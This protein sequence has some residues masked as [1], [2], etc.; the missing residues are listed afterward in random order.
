MYI[1]SRHNIIT[2]NCDFSTMI[3]NQPVPRARSFTCLGVKLDKILERDDHIEMIC[4]KVAAG[5][6]T[7]KRIKPYVPA[8]TL[9]IIY[10][11]LIPPYFEYCSPLWGVCTKTLKDKLKPYNPENNCRG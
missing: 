10:S 5:I 6:G 1:G 3:N 7:M 11:V 9:Q 8:N 4:K 2:V